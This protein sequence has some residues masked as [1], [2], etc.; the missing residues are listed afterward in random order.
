M[1]GKGTIVGRGMMP[2]GWGGVAGIVVPRLVPRENELRSVESKS[3]NALVRIGLL[4][5]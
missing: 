4:C 5:T 1:A 2:K 3:E